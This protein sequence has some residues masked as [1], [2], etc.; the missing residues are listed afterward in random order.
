MSQIQSFTL[1][2]HC[3]RNTRVHSVNKMQGIPNITADG[4]YCYH[5]VW[6]DNQ[7]IFLHFAHK[8]YLGSA[9]YSHI[10]HLLIYRQLQPFD[11][12]TVPKHARFDVL[13]KVIQVF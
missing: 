1:P 12:T 13:M 9:G 2:P 4:T 5:G 6:K 11:H 3:Y 8:V 7:K 10:A